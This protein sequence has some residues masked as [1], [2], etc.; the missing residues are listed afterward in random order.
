MNQAATASSTETVTFQGRYN[1][2]DYFQYTGAVHDVIH[3]TGL[4]AGSLLDI[5]DSGELSTTALTSEHIFTASSGGFIQYLKN[6]TSGAISGWAPDARILDLSGAGATTGIILPGMTLGN[7][8]VA[9]ISMTLQ[10]SISTSNAATS[11][12]LGNTSIGT[13][14]QAT[15]PAEFDAGLGTALASSNG[16][17]IRPTAL[18]PVSAGQ[19][20]TPLSIQ[21]YVQPGGFW[22]TVLRTQNE[23]CPSGGGTSCTTQIR[24]GLSLVPNGGAL[25]I[26]GATTI[27]GALTVT[28]AFTFTGTPTFGAVTLSGNHNTNIALSPTASTDTV[29]ITGPG[30][31]GGQSIFFDGSASVIAIN[32]RRPITG[33][34]QTGANDSSFGFADSNPNYGVAI[35]PF[36]LEA[37]VGGNNTGYQTMLYFEG[38]SAGTPGQF[39]GQTH[40]HLIPYSGAVDVGGSLAETGTGMFNVYGVMASNAWLPLTIYSAAGTPIPACA[41]S[42]LGRLSTVSDATSP[43]YMGAYTS[44][45]A[46][47]ARVICSYNGTA[48]AWLTD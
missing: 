47:T 25:T 43:T 46:I 24:P 17:L 31:L 27:N 40:L 22:D 16:M 48:Y 28:G 35:R 8:N 39:T 41:S 30:F 23:S 36:E 4:P 29:G 13:A 34:A 21:A 18:T 32:S 11:L 19:D 33:N 3:L 15:A 6:G 14:V 9:P 1:I 12:V 44:G 26:G 45:G 37:W 20:L 10:T 5:N 7:T 42:N 38:T 2:D